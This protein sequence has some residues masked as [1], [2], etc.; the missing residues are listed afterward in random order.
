M[1]YPGGIA[2]KLGERYEARWTAHCVLQMLRGEI[3]WIDLQ[4]LGPEGDGF[5]FVLERDGRREYHQVKRR[6]TGT[7]RWS[8][9]ALAANGVLRAF[10]QKLKAGGYTRFV[11]AQDADELHELAERARNAT[12]LADFDRHLGGDTWTER[13]LTLAS[14]MGLSE[15]LTF[16]ALQRV[17]VTVVGEEELQSW[18][19]ALAEPLI[20]A[21][22][23]DALAAL[24]ALTGAAVPGRLDAPSVWT[25]LNE[26][27]DKRPR[28]WDAD[29][30]L[31][32]RVNDL[33]GAYVSSLKGLR[34][35]HPLERAQVAETLSLL[36][37]EDLDGVMLTGGAGSGKSDVML[38]VVED[39]ASQSWPVLCIRADRLDATASPG[40]VGAQLQLP[41]SPVGVLAA[42]ATG[43][44]SL[45][46]IDQL[47][48]VSLASGRVTGLWDALYALIC[49]A[50]A[51]PGMRVL[52]ACR[53]FDVDNDHRMRALTGEQ[54]KLTALSVPPLDDAQVTE[55]LGAMNLDATALDGNQRSLLAVPLHL[56]LL[57]TIASDSQALTFTTL[58][59]L[60][61]RFWRRKQLD[62]DE[63]A[64]HRVKWADVIQTATRY[65]SEHRRLD[66]SAQHLEQAGL[67]SDANALVSENVL[68]EDRGSY[69][70][71]HESF[72]D[73]AFARFYLSDG[74]TIGELLTSENQDLFRRAQVRQLLNQQRDSDYQAYVKALSELL[75]RS[76]IRFHIKQ[77][78]TA[79]LATVADPRGEEL[80]VLALLL[81]ASDRSDPRLPLIWRTLSAPAWFDVAAADG[82]LD[83]WLSAEDDALVNG[84]TQ[85]LGAIVKERTEVVAGLLETH[86]DGSMLWRDRIAYV[87]RFGDVQSS[88]QLFE[89]LLD[90]LRRDAF[91]ASS[92]HDA[93]LYAHQLPNDRA[94]WAAE[95]LM[96][97]LQRAKVRAE[98]EGQIHA[99]HDGS[100]LKHEHSALEFITTLGESDPASLLSAVLPFMLAT[101]DA[102]LSASE[103]H[104]ERK[105]RL[106]VDNVWSYRLTDDIYTFDQVL[107]VATDKALHELAGA[108]PAAFEK[109]AR[110]LAERR[111]ETSQFLLYQG[112]LGNPSYFADYTAQV[113]LEGTWR[114]WAAYGGE[115][116]WVTHKLLEATAPHLSAELIGKLEHAILY[117]TTPYERL[118]HGRHS[119][120]R[121]E[122]EL[123]SGLAAGNI[124]R[125][126]Q[127]R[128]HELQRKFNTPEPEP[129]AG[130][131]GGFVRSPI[132][133]ERTQYMSDEDWLSA[134]AKHRERWE[135]KRSMDLIGGAS[136]L[137]SV[138][139]TVT[140]EEP[141]RFARLG[142][143]LTTDTMP[144]YVEH[145][146]IGLSQPSKD[147]PPAPL[148]SIVELV[149][150]LAGL[151][152]APGSRWLP[153]LIR[154]YADES[155][156]DDLLHL[157]ARIATEDPD[158]TEDVWK[159]DAG[160]GKTYYGGD[161]LSAGINSARGCG[162]EAIAALIYPRETRVA[163]LGPAVI[164][165]A[166]DPVTSVRACAAQAVHALMRWRRE[167]AIDLLMALV[168]TP[169]DGLLATNPVQRL[170]ASAIST[171]WGIVRRV[172]ERM[173]SSLEDDVREAGGTLASIAGLDQLD[174]AELL[175]EV[176]GHD[177]RRVRQGA[178][179][180]LAGHVVSG[181][182]RNRCTT[183]L[184]VL[185]DDDDADVRGEAA[186][187]FWGVRGRDLAELDGLARAFLASRAFEGGYQH[188]LHALEVSTT[189]VNDLAL[190][191]ADRMV[192]SY[193]DQ[194]GDMRG[195]VG[196]DSRTLSILLLRVLGTL[197]PD[198]SRVNHALDLLDAMLAAGAWGVSEAIETVER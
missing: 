172:V 122:F 70:F 86:D 15:E 170:I 110:T 18:N 129:P 197:E 105:G 118:A 81:R 71:F 87:V 91:L 22:P 153:V 145:L 12:D 61:E 119:R 196:G 106:P 19:E 14:Q 10:S 74:S 51:T 135:D 65:M 35:R 57:E 41:G 85:L 182:Y 9:T 115:P 148:R 30:S 116:F 174:A 36:R 149:R 117:F 175:K 4:P 126:A 165:L 64:G 134:I 114:Y 73:F 171:H 152:S 62:V 169:E 54:H 121:T 104:Q 13:F 38:Q 150:S 132:S 60:F 127:R 11:S 137:A 195:R 76:D 48:A 8:L 99:L 95:L 24:D 142:L 184:K 131:I 58:T 190:A 112:L 43:N 140:Q 46:V 192:E 2:A 128:L 66:L 108:D 93:W 90:A 21:V 160:N 157:V 156:P 77:L 130:I 50:R 72:F 5:E 124:S 79:W 146:L 78:V 191:T 163:L 42:I 185:F 89:L 166:S 92:D 167:E 159:I 103:P 82:L 97:L 173:L 26:Q 151:S 183:G 123:L 23:A 154:Q 168:D 186:K 187:A 177:D 20:E 17:E 162:A 84:A 67:L 109:W 27:Y 53:Q 141:E 189:D 29:Q 155:L 52:M 102:D 33:T 125:P 158:P 3:S 32:A 6:L 1:S 68:V 181:H 138:L 139:Q 133:P 25:T 100:P 94:S 143:R 179:K 96:V 75:N 44:P 193:G 120:G 180:V 47:D 101:L 63:H 59:Q 83:R 39:A 80:D 34:L 178:A 69:R 144:V 88:R 56:V 147:V 107:L 194:M 28:S 98:S 37:G 31:R 7:G 188:F 136:E 161:I 16:D 55:A 45:L 49:Q 40:G 164:K 176:V 111:D 198:R 113:L